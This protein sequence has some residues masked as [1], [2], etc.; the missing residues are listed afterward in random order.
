MTGS[1]AGSRGA[2]LRLR[3]ALLRPAVDAAELAAALATARAC[4]PVPVLWLL[5]AAQ[6]GKTSI[7]RALTGSSRA[8]IGDGFAPCTRT[9]R[10]YDFPPE[11]PVLSFLDTRGLGEVA[12]DPAEDLAL[13]EAQ[14]QL[15]IAVLR[16]SDTQAGAVREVLHA[17]RRRHP[18][19]PVVIAQ[20][21]LHHAYPPG[22]GHPRPYPFDQTGW[23]ARVGDDL[24]RLLLAQRAALGAL[25]G[26]AGTWW[27]PIDFTR[28]EDGFAPADYGLE[29]LWAALEAASALGLR[30]RLKADPGVTDVYARAA[31]PHLVGYSLAAAGLGALPLIDLALVPAL[32]AKMLQSLAGIYGLEWS[33]RHSAEFLG[34]LGAGTVVAWGVRFAGR[35]V[36]K[37]VPGW[38]QVLGAAWGASA[39]SGITWA[40]GKAACYYLA[41]RRAGHAVEQAALR[42]VFGEALREGVPAR[43]EEAGP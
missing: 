28:P 11:A 35:S 5:G 18:D 24:R 6:S 30:A 33:R 34:L 15:V 29:A 4:Q 3:R 1:D 32:Q 22:A 13:C 41:Q 17:I 38:G 23:E 26:T 2:W 16:A 25:P 9:A 31:H 7:V 21:C 42:R 36:V 40:L 20:S 10:R 39:S 37:L 12:Y 14:A 43:R 27:V 19:W 8:E